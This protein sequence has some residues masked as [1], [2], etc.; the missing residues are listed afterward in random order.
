MGST[1]GHGHGVDEVLARVD[2]DDAFSR[3]IAD[4]DAAAGCDRGIRKG[5]KRRR[6]NAEW[7]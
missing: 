5:P 3:S 1:G 6:L 7:T 4:A 2:S